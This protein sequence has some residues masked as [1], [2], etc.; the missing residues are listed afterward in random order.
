[1]LRLGR[2]MEATSQQLCMPECAPSCDS[3]PSVRFYRSFIPPDHKSFMLKCLSYVCFFIHPQK[4]WSCHG[5]VEYHALL[6]VASQD[7]SQHQFIYS[8]DVYTC[9]QVSSLMKDHLVKGGSWQVVHRMYRHASSAGRETTVRRLFK[10]RECAA[11][12]TIS[13]EDA[14]GY[15]FKDKGIMETA[16]THSYA[17]VEQDFWDFIHT[18]TLTMYCSH[19]AITTK[20][21]GVSTPRAG[22]MH[23]LYV[24]RKDI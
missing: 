20:E 19:H 11:D 7:S 3:W 1:M 21:F 4:W 9:V 15:R 17:S 6:T 14:L 2:A 16:V 23:R 5:S 24:N 10:P 12:T 13:I 18:P 8:R 22:Y